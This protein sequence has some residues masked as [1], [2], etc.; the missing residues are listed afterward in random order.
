MVNSGGDVSFLF[1]NSNDD[2][3]QA[4]LLTYKNAGNVSTGL[5]SLNSPSQFLNTQLW[6][7]GHGMGV[8]TGLYKYKI[9]FETFAD[10]SLKDQIDFRVYF[11]GGNDS[12][13]NY[14]TFTILDS[15]HLN[16]GAAADQ[17]FT[18]IGF[19]LIGADYPSGS[20]APASNENGVTLLSE[21]NG[22][23]VGTFKKYTRTKPEEPEV[24]EPSAFGLLAGVGAIALAVSRRRRSR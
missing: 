18:D 15:G 2:P 7:L 11:P 19:T 1:G 3:C 13:G 17:V 8:Q 10:S 16:C 9:V 4:G 6:T 20:N 23:E 21:W 24:P 22:E 5:Y 12:N 14:S